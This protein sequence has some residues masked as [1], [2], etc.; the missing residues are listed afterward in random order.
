MASFAKVEYAV[1]RMILKFQLIGSFQLGVA[2]NPLIPI[3]D[4][5][6]ARILA[7][8]AFEG[9]LCMRDEIVRRCWGE[10]RVAGRER[11]ED[12]AFPKQ[13]SNVRAIFT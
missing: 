10:Q 7:L 2:D 9:R 8:L 11:L 13:V 6:A 4:S 3:A 12:D 5:M 1:T